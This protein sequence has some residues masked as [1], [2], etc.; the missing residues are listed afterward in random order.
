MFEN[1]RAD[2][3]RTRS[4]EAWTFELEGIKGSETAGTPRWL[5][6]TP[7]DTNSRLS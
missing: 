7:R 5:R 3:V 1:L 4:D 6:T 2:F